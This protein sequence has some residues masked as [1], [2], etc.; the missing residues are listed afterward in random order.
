MK[1]YETQNKDR[2]DAIEKSVLGI[3]FPPIQRGGWVVGFASIMKMEFS[4]LMM[5]I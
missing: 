1:I 4:R 5:S 3:L 2:F